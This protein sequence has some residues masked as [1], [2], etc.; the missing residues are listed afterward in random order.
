MNLNMIRP[1]NQTENLSFSITK[2][3]GTLIE[4]THREPE[5]TLEFKMNK[6]RQIFHF[7]PPIQIQGFW[8]VGL[9]GL[10]VYNSIFNITERNNKFEL[11]KFP[12]KKVV[13]SHMKKLEMRLKKTW[14]FQILQLPIYKIIQSVRFLLKNMENKL[15]KE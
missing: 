11:Y 5:E 10:E 1:K 6:P 15:Q 3:C 12:D 9:A 14:I 2:S 7:N 13:V 8:M 4:Q